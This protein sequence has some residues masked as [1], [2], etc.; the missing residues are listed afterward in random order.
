MAGPAAGARA[1]TGLCVPSHRTNARPRAAR[2]RDMNAA[3]ATRAAGHRSHTRHG[4]DRRHTGNST[5]GPNSRN[6]YSRLNTPR[7]SPFVDTLPLDRGHR[8]LLRT[9]LCVAPDSCA[10]TPH[11]DAI[12][13]P[14]TAHAAINRC[15]YM[16]H[17]IHSCL[18]SYSSPR[19]EEG[20]HSRPVC[21]NVSHHPYSPPPIR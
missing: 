8:A 16:P 2:P 15:Q 3:Q 13:A 6:S 4:S 12:T 10:P 5:R 11:T 20:I 19:W 14:I 18:L 9:G 21:T 1:A 7:R 17:T